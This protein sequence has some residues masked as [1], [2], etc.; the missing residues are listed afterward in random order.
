LH[1]LTEDEISQ[2]KAANNYFEGLEIDLSSRELWD[3]SIFRGCQIKISEPGKNL[4]LKNARFLDVQFQLLEENAPGVTLLR[5]LIESDSPRLTKSVA[6]FSVT[7]N[8]PPLRLD[9]VLK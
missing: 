5:S 4:V 2:A 8:S 9:K 1:P 7:V 6:V 3:N